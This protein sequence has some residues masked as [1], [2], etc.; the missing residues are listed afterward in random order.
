MNENGWTPVRDIYC[1]SWLGDNINSNSPGSID[2]DLLPCLGDI[3]LRELNFDKERIARFL[4]NNPD[5][6]HILQAFAL[7]QPFHPYQ[8]QQLL[9]EFFSSPEVLKSL[10]IVDDKNEWRPL[11]VAPAKVGT[12]PSMNSP[13]S[14][15]KMTRMNGD[16]SQ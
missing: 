12:R 9:T 1:F 16:H 13:L 7:D 10:L 3:L 8:K 11:G 5:F 14:S 6:N 4:I 2:L 15:L